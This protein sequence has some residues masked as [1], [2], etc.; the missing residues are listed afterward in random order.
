MKY[1]IFERQVREF[2]INYPVSRLWDQKL[3]VLLGIHKDARKTFMET[4][5]STIEHGIVDYYKLL[6]EEKVNVRENGCLISYRDH[7]YSKGI[8]SHWKALLVLVDYYTTFPKELE[9][10]SEKDRVEFEIYRIFKELLK[11]GVKINNNNWQEQL[12]LQI[13]D[14]D[15]SVAT[16]KTEYKNLKIRVVEDDNS[17]I[18]FASLKIVGYLY[19]TLGVIDND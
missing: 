12:E 8:D 17:D 11:V 19:M 15:N 1:R 5:M 16:E 4:E 13:L 18:V 6:L 9:G 7:R 14:L 10:D 3:D 2:Y